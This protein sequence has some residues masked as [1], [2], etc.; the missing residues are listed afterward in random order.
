MVSLLGVFDWMEE[1]E[2][3]LEVCLQQYVLSGWLDGGAGRE[4]AM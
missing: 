2:A 4:I 1:V 3:L